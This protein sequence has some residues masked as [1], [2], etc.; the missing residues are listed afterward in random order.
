[1]EISGQAR[2]KG[3]VYIDGQGKLT[4][5]PPPFSSAQLIA[6]LPLCNGLTG[7]VCGTLVALL[8]VTGLQNTIDDLLT[9]KCLTILFVKSCLAAQSP[10]AIASALLSQ[11]SGWGPA[12]QE[13]DA[14]VSSVTTYGTSGTVQGTFREIPPS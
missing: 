4:V 12:V 9:G 8:N 7:I 11:L 5:T 13:D 14:A 6:S 2:V 3:A 10:T 1:V